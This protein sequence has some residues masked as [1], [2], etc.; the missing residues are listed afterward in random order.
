MSEQKLL[1]AVDDRRM[2]Q[3]LSKAQ[4]CGYH[5]MTYGEWIGPAHWLVNETSACDACILR[6]AKER[7][8]EWLLPALVD[9][10]DRSQGQMVKLESPISCESHLLA[11]EEQQCTGLAYWRASGYAWCDECI[12]DCLERTPDNRTWLTPALEDIAQ[13]KETG[14]ADRATYADGRY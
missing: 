2:L 4:A 1:P 14:N 9:I 3:K 5:F 8:G 13:R 12:M 7:N 11:Q 10:A 6:I